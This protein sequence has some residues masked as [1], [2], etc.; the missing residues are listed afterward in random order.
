MFVFR[1]GKLLKKLFNLTRVFLHGQQTKT[2]EGILLKKYPSMISSSKN[3]D[4][5]IFYFYDH[6]NNIMDYIELS[7]VPSPRNKWKDKP[8]LSYQWNKENYKSARNTFEPSRQSSQ[9]L[10]QYS[11]KPQLQSSLNQQTFSKYNPGGLIDTYRKIFLSLV[12][13]FRNLYIVVS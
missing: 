10:S 12:N 4:F 6:K 2:E 9:R 7:W 13:L 8:R 1:L 3:M 5:M 11:E